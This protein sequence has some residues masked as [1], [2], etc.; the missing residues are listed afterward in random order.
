MKIHSIHSEEEEGRLT[1]VKRV[2]AAPPKRGRAVEGLQW[3]RT[4]RGWSTHVSGP[5]CK[6]PPER[7]RHM[8]EQVQCLESVCNTKSLALALGHRS[9]F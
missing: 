8:R 3:P 7:P 2:L 1:K 5:R 9:C 6:M 4:A